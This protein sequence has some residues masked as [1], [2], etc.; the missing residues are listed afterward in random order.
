MM[1]INENKS[2]STFFEKQSRLLFF[3]EEPT[4]DVDLQFCKV[5][6]AKPIKN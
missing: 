3:E 5:S 1:R 6:T 2:N 4:G